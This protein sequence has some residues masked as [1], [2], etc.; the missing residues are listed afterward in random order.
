VG[1]E[2]ILAELLEAQEDQV[3]HLLKERLVVEV[4]PEEHLEV[5]VEAYQLKVVQEV[6][7]VALEQEDL[8]VIQV[9]LP[10]EEGQ[11][12]NLEP[13]LLVEDQEAFQVVVAQKEEVLEALKEDQLKLLV[14]EVL[15]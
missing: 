15:P 6:N 7:P 10:L 8:E 9:E 1:L 4:I 5:L 3:G 12:A 14:E 2:V 13:Y 11:V